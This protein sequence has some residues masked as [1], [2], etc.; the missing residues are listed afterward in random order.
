MNDYE[1]LG[2]REGASTEEIKNAYKIKML[3]YQ[4]LGENRTEADEIEFN[5]IDAA[6]NRLC[7]YD[8]EVKPEKH[9]SIK[10]FFYYNKEKFLVGALVVILIVFFVVQLAQRVDYDFNISIIGNITVDTE[11]AEEIGTN[12]IKSISETVKANVYGIKEPVVVNYPRSEKKNEDGSYK[13]AHNETYMSMQQKLVLE[14]QFGTL[15][16]LILDTE[17]YEEFLGKEY[18]LS[19]NEYVEKYSSQKEIP[20]KLLKKEG[21]EIYGILL[22]GNEFIEQLRLKYDGDLIACIY[23][24]SQRGEIAFAAIEALSLDFK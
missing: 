10:D 2:L 11:G 8:I 18:L 7:G 5:E 13:L 20:E 22:T 23:K 9:Q 17:I 24:G 6:Y 12:V 1:K 15:D 4:Q 14:L 21:E 19:L 3:K 16:L